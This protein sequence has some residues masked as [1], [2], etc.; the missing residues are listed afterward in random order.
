MKALAAAGLLL[1]SA[2]V[3]ET[4][5]FEDMEAGL[6]PPGWV[7]AQA[8]KRSDPP[9]WEVIRDAGAPARGNVLAQLARDRDFRRFPLA[10]YERLEVAD[11]RVAVRFKP[12]LGG[13]AKA[14]GLVWRYRD[15]NNYYVVAADALR[16]NVVLLKIESG[17]RRELASAGRRTPFDE[18]SVPLDLPVGQWSTLAVSFSGPRFQVLLNGTE[19]FEVEDSTFLGPGRV[20]LWTMADSISYFDDFEVSS[21]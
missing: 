8:R 17:R 12:V 7:F 18:F 5:D 19:L 2:A 6:A 9:R 10:L 14:A 20:G 15:E 11:G 4:V 21:P 1:A 3:G 13:A 16:E